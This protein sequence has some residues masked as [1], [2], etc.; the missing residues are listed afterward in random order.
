MKRK[1]KTGFVSCL[2]CCGCCWCYCFSNRVM[3]KHRAYEMDVRSF[4]SQHTR[5]ERETSIPIDS[6][7]S[8]VTNSHEITFIGALCHACLYTICFYVRA[9]AH[10]FIAPSCSHIS[11]LAPCVWMWHGIWISLDVHSFRTLITSPKLW[12]KSSNKFFH[13]KDS[14][15]CSLCIGFATFL[16]RAFAFLFS[17]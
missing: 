8:F 15:R 9:D 1:V 17:C 12:I 3:N 10:M 4:S 13:P 11:S 7:W 2:I 16:S 6:F 14:V 5:R